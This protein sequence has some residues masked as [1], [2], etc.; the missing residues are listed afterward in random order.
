MFRRFECWTRIAG[1]IARVAFENENAGEGI[2]RRL[3][4][5]GWS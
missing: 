1:H 4:L 3:A 5:M 2:R